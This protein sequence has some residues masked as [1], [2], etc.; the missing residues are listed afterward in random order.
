MLPQALGMFE[1][2]SKRDSILDFLGL[3]MGGMTGATCLEILWK[4]RMVW[5]RV[6]PYGMKWVFCT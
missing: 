4:W 1:E 3:L 6:L 5:G 2:S